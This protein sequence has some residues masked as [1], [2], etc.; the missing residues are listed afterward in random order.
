MQ[1]A[2]KQILVGR[3]HVS[4]HTHTRTHT[5]KT[6]HWWHEKK[7]ATHEKNATVLGQRLNF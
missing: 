4:I 7:N 6:V 3:D 2:P 5:H 1:R